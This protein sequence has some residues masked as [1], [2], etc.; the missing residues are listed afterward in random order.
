MSSSFLGF[1]EADIKLGDLRLKEFLMG[2]LPVDARTSCSRHGRP[3]TG[4]QRARSLDVVADDCGGDIPAR[5][6]VLTDQLGL[7]GSEEAFDDGVVVAIARATHG[8]NDALLT[9]DGR[10]CKGS[11]ASRFV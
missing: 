9:K 11:T 7:E 4:L 6:H 3:P 5:V 2:S 10:I 8:G 1:A